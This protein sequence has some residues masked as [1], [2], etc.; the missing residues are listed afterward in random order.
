VHDGVITYEYLLAYVNDAAWVETP[1]RP[2]A[3]P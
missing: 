3:K 1:P 2:R